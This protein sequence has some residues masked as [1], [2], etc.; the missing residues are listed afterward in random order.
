M[1]FRNIHFIINPVAGNGKSPLTKEYLE[2]YFINSFHHLSVKYSTHKKHAI[3]LAKTSIAEGADIIVA[4]GGDGTVN[5]VASSLVGTSIPLGIIPIGSGN[6]LASNLCIPKNLRRALELIKNSHTVR[7]DVGRINDKYFFSNTGIGFDASVIKNYESSE[8]RTLKGYLMACLRT[9][10]QLKQSGDIQI[11]INDLNIL[12]DP[13]MIFASNSNEMGYKLSLTP[14]A[15]L[16]D[17]LLDVLIIS[18]IG[19]FKMLLLGFLMILNKS[20][21][22]K[23][24]KSFQTKSLVLINQGGNSLHSQIDGELHKVPNGRISIQI[25]EHE[26]EVIV[27]ENLI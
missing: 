6:G 9:F 27:P 18:K 25:E 14:K 22:M 15:S 1:G 11:C 20:H 3:K 13:F 26:L 2:Q 24:V 19:R 7:I 17:G 4:C 16:K 10:R 12:T 8:G 23:E 5:E 21:L